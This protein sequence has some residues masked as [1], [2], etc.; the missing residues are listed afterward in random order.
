MYTKCSVRSFD[1][2]I[3]M[4]IFI[5]CTLISKRKIRNFN[6]FFVFCAYDL[7]QFMK[8]Y[9]TQACF[10]VSGQL[11]PAVTETGYGRSV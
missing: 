4:Y 10:P 11:I 9:L 3:N 7:Y 2:Y 1:S 8:Q 6:I 5:F